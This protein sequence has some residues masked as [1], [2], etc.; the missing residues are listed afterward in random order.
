MRGKLTI[1]G[2]LLFIA[3]YV[4]SCVVSSPRGYHDGGGR[5]GYRSGRSGGYHGGG[6]RHY[7]GR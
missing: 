7:P 5:G 4:S 6:V 3:V 1:A 2:A